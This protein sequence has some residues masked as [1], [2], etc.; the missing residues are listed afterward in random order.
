[1][2]MTHV[3]GEKRGEIVLYALST[4]VWCKKTKELLESLN[5][6]FHYTHVDLLAE[7]EKEDTL[8]EIK[9]WNPR[10]SFPSLVIN[11]GQCIVGYDE[12]KIRGAVEHD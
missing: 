3:E 9:K 12:N 4:C 10:C 5:V 8:E 1:M 6:D 11:N 2:T 7:K